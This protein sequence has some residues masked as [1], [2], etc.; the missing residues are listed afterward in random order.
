MKCL[1]ILWIKVIDSTSLGFDDHFNE[2]LKQDSKKTKN[3]KKDSLKAE[4]KAPQ[5]GG[6]G[7]VKK[8]K[9]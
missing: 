9:N 1:N 6:G 2:S 3:G 7:I 5:E 8:G 4:S